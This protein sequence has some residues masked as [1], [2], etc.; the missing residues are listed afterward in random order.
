MKVNVATLYLSFVFFAYVC[1][2]IAFSEK[3]IP[4]I[5]NQCDEYM[6]N[7]TT[8]GRFGKGSKRF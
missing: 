7:K 4:G 8:A 1:K 6:N 2:N 3:F 5:N